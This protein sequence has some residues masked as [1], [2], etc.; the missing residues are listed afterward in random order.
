[1]RVRIDQ[2]WQKNNVAQFRYGLNAGINSADGDDTFARDA[3]IAAFYWRPVD[4]QNPAGT[5]REW[6]CIAQ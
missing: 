6:H 3:D 2:S 1:M 5:Q 4:R